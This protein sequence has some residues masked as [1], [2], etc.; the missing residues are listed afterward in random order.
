[1]VPYIFGGGKPVLINPAECPLCGQQNRC[2][3][4]AGKPIEDCWCKKVSIP[5]ALRDRI[6]P[7][8]RAKACICRACVEQYQAQARLDT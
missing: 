5:K 8:K 6:P 4:H 3:V 2:A 1:M 7:E